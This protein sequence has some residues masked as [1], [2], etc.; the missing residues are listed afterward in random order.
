MYSN[1][2]HEAIHQK[3]VKPALNNRLHDTPGRIM[4]YNNNTNRA[5]VQFKSPVSGEELIHNNIPIEL[6]SGGFHSAGPF[7]GDQ[8]W[9]S[10]RQG[11]AN[12]PYISAFID[13]E[14]EL[15][16]RQSRLLHKR[17]GPMVPD[18]IGRR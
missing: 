1:P 5:T 9:L 15:G 6:G 7:V 8:V 11:N 4:K 18:S 17:Q 2:L 10:F 13:E 14:Y 3:V 16:R 12:N